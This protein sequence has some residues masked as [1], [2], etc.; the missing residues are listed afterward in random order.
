[1]NYKRIA[2]GIILASL[3]VMRI[4]SAQE[5][6]KKVR[7]PEP[8]HKEDIGLR[9]LEE[10]IN[11]ISVLGRLSSEKHDPEEWL[12]LHA[13]NAETYLITG[14][15]GEKLKNSLLELGENNLVSVTGIRDGRSHISCDQSYKYEYNKK[16]ERELKIDTKCIRYYDL[17][18]TQIL[19]AKKSDEEIPPPKRDIEEERRLTKRTGQQSLIQPIVGEIYGV[20]SFIN[21]KSPIKTVEIANRDK[22]S[23]LKK[24][25]LIISPDTRIAKKI[26]E[27]EP[28]AFGVNALRAGQEV[29]C[30]YSR[31]ELKSEA[32]F[33]TITK[34]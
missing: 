27:E 21:L 7:I 2:L 11:T 33:I 10:E 1:M 26:G 14:S 5:V 6:E 28:M 9:K 3:M 12:V 24:I 17:G 15:L 32:L 20:V 25:T 34:D 8:Q 31:G 13:K 4:S 23:P 19:F 22:D 30:M 29:T 18:V 16:G